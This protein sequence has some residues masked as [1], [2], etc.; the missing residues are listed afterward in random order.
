MINMS[1]PATETNGVNLAAA[2]P[3]DELIKED[4]GFR[5]HVGNLPYKVTEEQIRDFMSQVGDEILTVII[6]MKVRRPAG[7]AFVHFKTEEGANKAVEQ[8]NDSELG[9]RKVSLQIARSRE[10]QAERRE[11]AVEKREA[12][13]AARAA[14]QEAAGQTEG[15][16]V[17]GEA[18]PK[19]KRSP[20]TREPRRRLPEEGEETVEA[21]GEVSED[22]EKP[23]RPPRTR[24]PREAR[25]DGADGEQERE[26]KPRERKERKPRLE[27]TGEESESTIFVANLPFSVNDDELAA[28]FTN[29]SIRVKSA[30]VIRG[31]RKGRGGRPFRA[32][33]GFGFVEV[34]DASQQKEAV[35]KVEGSLIGDR[36]ISAKVANEMKPI[37]VEEVAEAA[38]IDGTPVPVAA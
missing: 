25:I 17:N 16:V 35:E 23:K 15:E 22:A 24:K 27:L 14:N 5:V 21:T 33:K 37:E 3:A 31:L 20:K 2:K 32:S 18:E 28:I 29:L 13:R 34:E 12:T 7:F 10:E 9:K 38:D 6:P 4:E 19:K 26:R 11:A 30:K 1:E 36:K 8:L